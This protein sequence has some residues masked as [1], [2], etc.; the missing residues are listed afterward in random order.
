MVE[1]I[2]E[3]IDFQVTDRQALATRQASGSNCL[4][5]S[6]RHAIGDN[7][8]FDFVDGGRPCHM[9]PGKSTADCDIY[10]GAQGKVG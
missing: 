6:L 10:A 4:I 3:H 7:H 9:A 8:S 2:N 1:L 5:A